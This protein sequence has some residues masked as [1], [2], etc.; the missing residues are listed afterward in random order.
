MQKIT[1]HWL[2]YSQLSID[3]L[4]D[5][6]SLRQ[7]IFIVEQ[8]CPY[9]DADGLDRRAWHLLG[10]RDGELVAYLRV[11]EP[12]RK[13]TEPCIGRVVTRQKVRRTGVGKELMREGIRRVEELFPGQGIR[14]SAQ[15]HLEKFYGEFGFRAVRG[16]YDEDGIPHFEM[17]RQPG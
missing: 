16:P 6:L 9:L 8:N 17:L 13:F 10:Y 4:Y 1:W 12:A 14:I 5:I 11:V 15:A 2:K 7:A 3:Q